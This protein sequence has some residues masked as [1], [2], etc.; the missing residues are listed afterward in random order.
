METFND[1]HSDFITIE[2]YNDI[3]YIWND[4]HEKHYASRDEVPKFTITKENYNQVIEQ[5]NLN[6]IEPAPYLVLTKDE[7]GFVNLEPKR[8]LS[9]DD[10]DFI[11]SEKLLAEKYGFAKDFFKN[12]RRYQKKRL[13]FRIQGSRENYE[14]IKTQQNT[15]KK[16]FGL[17]NVLS[18]NFF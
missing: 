3:V 16:V 7:D 15:N 17:L 1:L 9:Q 13:I 2:I 11:A 14:K 12:D 6:I 8:T 4:F 10:L 18:A 5:W